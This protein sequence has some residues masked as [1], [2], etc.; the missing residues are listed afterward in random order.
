L[1]NSDRFR[2]SE[3]PDRQTD[4]P[5]SDRAS[6]PSDSGKPQKRLK[7]EQYEL[8]VR[9]ETA[10]QVLEVTPT[11]VRFDFNTPL[12]VGT[13][14]P[15]SL[16]AP[17][18]AFSTT[19]EVSRC[20]LTVDSATGRFF[21]VTGKFFPY[22]EWA[23]GVARSP[24]SFPVFRFSFPEPVGHVPRRNADFAIVRQPVL[25]ERL[26]EIGELE[27]MNRGRFRPADFFERGDDPERSGLEPLDRALENRA[28]PGAV[29]PPHHH[30]VELF[31]DRPDRVSRRALGRAGR[32]A[33]RFEKRRD[34]VRN[35]DEKEALGARELQPGDELRRILELHDRV[36]RSRSNVWLAPHFGLARASL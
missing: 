4:P 31:L 23:R 3:M 24:R 6:R 36:N 18:V 15:V 2:L 30:R 26:D 19:L 34:L 7:P 9:W 25:R 12:K 28:W 13:R 5:G 8:K 22:V 11:G 14:Y 32:S 27:A 1:E 20:Q 21:R 16:K 33:S 35:V 17:G 29:F 10:R